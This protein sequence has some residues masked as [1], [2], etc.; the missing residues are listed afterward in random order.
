MLTQFLST[1]SFATL[2]TIAQPAAEE[3]RPPSVK[4]ALVPVLVLIGSVMNA[5]LTKTQALGTRAVDCQVTL[6]LGCPSKDYPLQVDEGG[7]THPL[8]TVP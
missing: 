2:H 8:W 7:K 5:D 1:M 6:A 3:D 4:L